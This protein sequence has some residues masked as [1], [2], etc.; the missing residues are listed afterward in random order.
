MI[1][2]VVTEGKVKPYVFP[3]I[4]RGLLQLERKDAL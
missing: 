3:L 4:E 2:S 1:L